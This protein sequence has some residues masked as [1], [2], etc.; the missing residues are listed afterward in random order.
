MVSGVPV[1]TAPGEIDLTTADQLSRADCG[2]L[3]LVTSADGIVPRIFARTSLDSLIPC[4]ASLKEAL[5]ATA[6]PGVDQRQTG[7]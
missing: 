6:G 7:S 1:V 4:F 2:E 5:T 3:R